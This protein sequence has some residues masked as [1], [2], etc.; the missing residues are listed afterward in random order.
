MLEQKFKT[1]DIVE[2]K[3]GS[4]KM[5]IEDVQESNEYVD[6]A[7]FDGNTLKRGTFIVDVLKR[8]I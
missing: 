5:T 8:S 4:P 1:G 3:S 7:W 6:C 2:L